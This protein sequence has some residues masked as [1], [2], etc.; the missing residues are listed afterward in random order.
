MSNY[1]DSLNNIAEAIQEVEGSTKA[2]KVAEMPD[3]IKA[4]GGSTKPVVLILNNFAPTPNDDPKPELAKNPDAGYQYEICVVNKI[5]GTAKD[6]FTA[7]FT[8]PEKIS[9][10]FGNDYSPVKSGNP[11]TKYDVVSIDNLGTISLPLFKKTPTWANIYLNNSQGIAI[12]FDTYNQGDGSTYQ[13]RTY[14]CVIIP[15][16]FDEDGSGSGSGSGNQDGDNQTGP[17]LPP[18]FVPISNN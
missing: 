15:N 5:S 8:T 13:R 16:I 1:L 18:P 17:I 9:L 2:M 3:R 10:N 6:F 7:L 11:F 14:L 4:L 12:W